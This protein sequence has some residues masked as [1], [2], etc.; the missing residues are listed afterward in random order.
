MRFTA[1][2][3]GAY[4]IV[5]VL[6]LLA[7]L[8]AA[9]SGPR[10][11]WSSEISLV[12]VAYVEVEGRR[13]QDCAFVPDERWDDLLAEV[14]LTPAPASATRKRLWEESNAML[15]ISLERSNLLVTIH[16][17]DSGDA[18]VVLH[19]AGAG[20]H[21]WAMMKSPEKFLGFLEDACRKR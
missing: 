14:R 17:D 21:T 8:A 15:S 20:Q 10:L 13:V 9:S 3:L 2:S 4:G 12:N 11:P 7:M 6:A 5:L 16:H 19:D 1:Y 18:V